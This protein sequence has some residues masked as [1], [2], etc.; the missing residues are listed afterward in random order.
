MQGSYTM[1]TPDGVTFDAEI[2]PFTL[3]TP[4]ALN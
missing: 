1:A 2:A 4:N 3:A